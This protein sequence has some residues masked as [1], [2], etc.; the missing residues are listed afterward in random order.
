MQF[1]FIWESIG[2]YE[3][4]LLSFR[5]SLEIASKTLNPSHSFIATI[6]YS[7]GVVSVEIGQIKEAIESF[8][9]SLDSAIRN[10]G[11]DHIDVADIRF[12]L[13][14]AL[15]EAGELNKAIDQFEIGYKQLH[16]GSFLLEI[17]RCYELKQQYNLACE[18]FLRVAE[19]WKE[20]YG[21]E[22]EDVLDAASNVYR[23]VNS[24]NINLIIPD[25]IIEE[26]Q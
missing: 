18:Y 4:S 21:L 25:W 22:D 14:C 26:M 11:K 24:F 12:Q 6:H 1:R 5:K 15:K 2:E 13:G 3:K 20:E 8:K 19:Q 9:F 10:L 23:L 7:M 17:A 16:K